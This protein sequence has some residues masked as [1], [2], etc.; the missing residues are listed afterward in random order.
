MN[1]LVLR[2]GGHFWPCP[3]LKNDLEVCAHQSVYAL[4]A[5][6]ERARHEGPHR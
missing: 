1:H 5:S 3:R 4:V 2:A 6:P